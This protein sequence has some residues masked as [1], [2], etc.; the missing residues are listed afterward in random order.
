MK[1]MVGFKATKEF[2]SF[3]QGMAKAENRSLSNF[4]VNALLTY[5]REHSGIEWQPTGEDGE[6]E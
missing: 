2:K 5:I 1:I 6:V 3:L 4:I